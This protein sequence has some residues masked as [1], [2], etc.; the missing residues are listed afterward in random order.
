M[1]RYIK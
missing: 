1:S